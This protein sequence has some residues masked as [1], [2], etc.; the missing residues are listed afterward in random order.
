LQADVEPHPNYMY[1]ATQVW[2]FD[3]GNTVSDGPG[4]GHLL[5]P[6]GII[7]IY[8][9]DVDNVS[10]LSVCLTV[11]MADIAI[12]LFTFSCLSMLIIVK[13]KQK[14]EL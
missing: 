11:E 4:I 12:P 2:E 6:S 13:Q 10:T 5:N 1:E 7:R 8:P 14:L 3:D 9:L